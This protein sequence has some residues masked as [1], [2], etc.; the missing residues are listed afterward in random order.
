MKL[1]RKEASKPETI[2]GFYWDVSLFISRQKMASW[3]D[4][5]NCYSFP[6]KCILW[7]S[8][9]ALNSSR[10]VVFVQSHADVALHKKSLKLGQQLS[11]N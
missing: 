6:Q 7:V 3:F 1:A 11:S 4:L 8:I 5:S 2:S 9:P 10:I